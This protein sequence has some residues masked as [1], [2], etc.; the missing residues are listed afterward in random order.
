MEENIRSEDWNLVHQTL[1][2]N[3]AGTMFDVRERLV[4]PRTVAVYTARKT[5]RYSLTFLCTW[6]T[7]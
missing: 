3:G 1:S 4:S 2:A 7:R 6:N 5:I